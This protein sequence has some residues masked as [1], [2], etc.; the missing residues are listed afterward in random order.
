MPKTDVPLSQAPFSA[1]YKSI[2]EEILDNFY[3]EFASSPT[4]K[5]KYYQIGRQ[6]LRLLQAKTQAAACRGL[7][8]TASGRSFGV[9]GP[10]LYEIKAQGATKI[11][12]GSLKTYAGTVRF[13][14]NGTQ[15]ILVDGQYGYIYELISNV[16]HRI[17]D[18][19]FP[20]VE[21]PTQGPSHVCC[22]DT[23]FIVNSTGTNRYYWSSPGYVPYAF[24]STHPDVLNLWNGLQFGVKGAT[25]GNIT[26][27]IANG[28]QLY[29]YGANDL[30]VHYNTGR[31]QGQLFARVEGAYV[32]AG[33]LA[34]QSLVRYINDV[35]WIGTDSN[36]TIGVFSCG[37]NYQPQRISVRGVEARMQMYKGIEDAFASAF[38][39]DGHAFVAFTFPRGT[40]TDGSDDTAGATWLYDCASKTWARR[41]KWD[42]ATGTSFRWQAQYVTYNWSKLIMGDQDTDAVYQLDTQYHA[43]DKADASGVYYINRV[44]T[45][46]V[47]WNSGINMV[48]RSIQ[49]NMQQGQGVRT[50]QGSNPKAMMSI[51]IDAGFTYGHEREAPI[52]VTG[53]YVQR[54]RWTKC[55]IGRNRQERFRITEPIPVIITGLTIDGEAL[56]R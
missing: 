4:A 29:V 49:L 13:A 8:T 37:P 38:F 7:F 30:E 9:F 26:G 39:I 16:M 1:P 18:P 50:G 6:G 36:G 17:T 3:L 53:N 21:D 20:G 35:F 41:T 34:P 54:T 27:L 46:P 23:Y 11:K 55:G 45:T 42:D 22:I 48:Y 52:G 10:H 24:D 33:L 12:V 25:S 51:S 28:T 2:G 56:S 32:M 40:S 15:I 31:T 43:D 19:Y 14:E 44:V 47:G 5:A